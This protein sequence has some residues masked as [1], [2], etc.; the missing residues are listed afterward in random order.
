LAEGGKP[1]MISNVDTSSAPSRTSAVVL[2]AGMS[3]RMG[4]P[5]QLLRAGE[6]TLLERALN[7]VRQSC[8]DEII[9][10]LGF[11]AKEIQ[12]SISTLGIK[13]V[14]NEGYQEGMG[15]SLRAGI[16]AVHPQAQAALIMLADQPFVLPSTLDRLIEHHQKARPQIVIPTYKGF[17]GN[18]V[19][20]D[21]S[22][23]PEVANLTGDIG[24]RAIFG[25]H[26]E[27]IARLAV[28]DA[29]ILFDVDT[30]E[31]FEKLTVAPAL[32]RVEVETANPPD[33][34][35]ATLIHPE[36]VVVGKDPV[37]QALMKLARLLGFSTT[38]IDP[39]LSLSE[40]P[41]AGQ[42]LHVLDF[43]RLPANR[44]R[45]IVVASRGQFDEEALEQAMQSD[46]IYVGLLANL[47][48]SQEL[49]ESMQRKGVAADRLARLRAPAGLDIGAKDPEE[50]AL[51]IMAEI[52]AERRGHGES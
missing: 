25:K 26:T 18:P 52:V 48:R 31:D 19:L 43:S 10:V 2:A 40:V 20:L 21:R 6:T 24:C 50:I 39:F 33:E 4:S 11:G 17:R 14:V 7:T 8:A 1:H 45:S 44:D 16:S 13:V 47:K 37:A 3:K 51:S 30:R 9:L 35:G 34:T 38:V 27:N 15:S 23:F 36:L 22:V 5:K 42:V 12:Q 41:G 46:A 32:P 29:G 28:D 49:R